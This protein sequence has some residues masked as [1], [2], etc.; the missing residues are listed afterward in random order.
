M[1]FKNPPVAT[2]RL[3]QQEVGMEKISGI[4]PK[5][6]RVSS[7]DM[8]DSAPV[9]PGT[10]SFG[11]PEGVS[12]LREAAIGQTASRATKIQSERM[13]WKTKDM[14]QAAMARELSDNFFRSRVAQPEIAESMGNVSEPVATYNAE[15]VST[16]VTYAPISG[17]ANTDSEAASEAPSELYPRGSFIDVQA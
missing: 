4:L 1:R 17:F 7:V 16:P 13:D 2:I 11:R 8:K 15:A 10:P 5:S 14:Q 9:R 6:A 3:N 12:S